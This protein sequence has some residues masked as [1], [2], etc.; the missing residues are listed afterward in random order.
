[1]RTLI[2]LL[3]LLF[4]SA[5]VGSPF[6]P[7]AHYVVDIYDPATGNLVKH[8]ESSSERDFETIK[9]QYGEFTLEAGAVT[10]PPDPYAQMMQN[11]MGEALKAYLKTP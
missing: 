3:L 6:G 1:M 9:T 10:T 2:A 5:C 11:L 7:S 8:F 4:L